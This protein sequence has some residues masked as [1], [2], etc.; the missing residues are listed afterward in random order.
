MLSDLYINSHEL[1]C[2]DVTC[3]VAS[4]ANCEVWG[5]SKLEMTL[6]LW[7]ISLRYMWKEEP[8]VCS[9]ERVSAGIWAV[10]L[11]CPC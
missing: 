1:G 7:T 6:V 3:L 4:C 11:H 5:Q 2:H 10:L 9:E 8:E